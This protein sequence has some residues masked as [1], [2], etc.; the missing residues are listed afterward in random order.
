[1][2]GGRPPKYHPIETLAKTREYVRDYKT[3]GNEEVIPTIAGLAFFLKVRR[4]TIYAWAKEEEKHEFSNIVADLMS[5]QEFVLM[6]E[7]L[8][9]NINPTLTKLALTK[10]GYSDKSEI[11]GL[12]GG[13]I[14]MVH[15]T[16]YE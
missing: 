11:G 2:P 15:V 5:K 14:K 10:H 1:M 7:G 16:E 4:E 8:K 9:G 6:N 12:G 3:L 13:A